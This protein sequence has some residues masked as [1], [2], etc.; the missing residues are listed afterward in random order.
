MVTSFLLIIVGHYLQV[1]FIY[2]VIIMA[3][4]FCLILAIRAPMNVY[5]DDIALKV[6]NKNEQEE[7]IT[8]L[9]VARN[10]GNL[11]LSTIF[12]FV[13]VKYELIVVIFSLLALSIIGLIINKILYCR[14]KSTYKKER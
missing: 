11:L 9:G 4:G 6:V 10:I 8:K 12:T 3:I 13:L 2:K 7:I 5:L 14:L 1:D